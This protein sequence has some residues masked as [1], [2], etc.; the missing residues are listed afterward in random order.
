MDSLELTPTQKSQLHEVA[1]L[2]LEIYHTLARMR[3]LNEAWIQPGP[4]KID[5]LMPLYHRLRLDPSIIYL[6]HILPYIDQAHEREVDFFHGS[7]FADFRLEDN[8]EYARDPFYAAYGRDP[9]GGVMR[10]WMTPLS[11]LG[12]HHSCIIYSA[13]KH[14]IWI[15]DQEFWGTTD[16]VLCRTWY[17]GSKMGSSED[18]ASDSEEFV[19]VN[20]A[21]VVRSQEEKAGSEQGSVES[22]QG[23]EGV[24]GTQTEEGTV[25]GEIETIESESEEDTADSEGDYDDLRSRPAGEVL[26]DIVRWYHE[27]KE[28]PGGGENTGVEWEGEVTKRLYHKHGWLGKTSCGRMPLVKLSTLQRIRCG[29]WTRLRDRAS[30]SNSPIHQEIRERLAAAKTVDE[31]WL[32]CWDL[33]EKEQPYVN[34]LKD[35]EEAE[36]EAERRCPGGQC[37]RPEDLPLWE[38]EEMRHSTMSHTEHVEGMRRMAEETQHSGSKNASAFQIKLRHAEDQAMIYQ[39]AYEAARADAE[40]LCPGRSATS[41]PG[42][43]CLEGRSAAKARQDLIKRIEKSQRIVEANREWATQLPQGA[44]QAK[45]KVKKR[46]EQYEC[47]IAGSRQQLVVIAEKEQSCEKAT[48]HD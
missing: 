13:K 9:E 46:I 30:D 4:H 7:Y 39:R 20:R 11:L 31:E 23:T 8:V 29:K 2:M 27:L 47:A 10:P 44:D 42:I 41:V 28:T 3:Y 1:D 40:R 18:E 24:E 17:D 45:K 12:N 21:E 16:P 33:W 15:I 38:A 32:A 34:A 43:E 5:A 25:E 48:V 14:Q 6:Y 22:K 35:L 26:R 37:Q 19:V 36:K